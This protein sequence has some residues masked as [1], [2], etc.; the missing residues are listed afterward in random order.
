MERPGEWLDRT[1]KVAPEGE[2]YASESRSTSLSFR[3]GELKEVKASETSGVAL[4]ARKDGRLGFA[5]AYGPAP[6][7]R[8]LANLEASLRLGEPSPRGFAPP[9]PPTPVEGLWDRH[10]EALNTSTLVGLG[11]FLLDRLGRE[12]PDYVFD[13]GLARTLGRVRYANTGGHAYEGA[14]TSF[15]LWVEFN[16]PS[17]DDMLLDVESHASVGL[18]GHEELVDRLLEKL[19]RARRDASLAPGRMPVIFSPGA[20]MVM[21]GPLA[22]ALNGKQVAHGTS[23]LAGRLGEKVFDEKLTVVDDGTLDGA[24]GSGPY[25]DEG[26]PTRRTVLVDRGVVRSFYHSLETAA[27]TGQEPTGNGTRAGLGAQPSPSPSNLL[28]LPG[29]PTQAEMVRAVDYG[30]LVDSLIGVGQS[31][32]LAGA[33]SNPVG[34]GFLIEKGE[35]AGRVKDVSVAGNIYE[36]LAELTALSSDVQNV[37]GA[38]RLPA[39]RVDSIKV[40]G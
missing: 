12:C 25:D 18:E 36:V 4:R 1:S 14:A 38:Y 30:L 8:L 19:R 6:E 23:P 5:V 27:E 33:F 9:S 11:R 26:L 37:Y 13:C 20:A 40:V 35:V 31:N 3:S 16:R 2:A 28:V 17:R 22:T 29:G 32:T 24:V 39:F 15:S 10:L 7:A 21:V 34:V